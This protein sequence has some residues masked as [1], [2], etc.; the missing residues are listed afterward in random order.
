MK[1]DGHAATTVHGLFA[2]GE[3]AGGQHGANRP[4]GN[5]LMDSQVMGKIAGESAAA[6]AKATKPGPPKPRRMAKTAAKGEPID[7]R[8]VRRTIRRL[9]SMRASIKRT[10]EGVKEGLAQLAAL[11][12]R[13]WD[14]AEAGEEYLAETRSIALVAEMVLAACGARTESR[15]PH[16]YFD[17][18]D[19][20][21]PLPRRDPEWQRYLVL[22]RGSRGRISIEARKPLEP[23]W[24]LVQEINA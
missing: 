8:E 17:S 1:I 7:I 6:L 20:I 5:A 21:A 23:D 14:A 15:G 9:M 24:E 3:V 4:G 18:P 13:P 12:K 16:L 11:A 2:A 19:S 22:H 10:A